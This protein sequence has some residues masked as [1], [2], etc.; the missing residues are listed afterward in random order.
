M[1]EPT[2]RERLLARRL[3][4]KG[5][6]APPDEDFLAEYPLLFDLLVRPLIVGGKVMEMPR[7]SL[8]VGDGDW[9]LTVSDGV[10]CQSLTVRETSLAD[11]LALMELT[12]GAEDAKWVAWRNREP[13]L[14]KTPPDKSQNSLD[15][16][17]G[18]G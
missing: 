9:I 15:N 13:R 1:S 18:G 6:T 17:S 12:V 7:L 10:L 5:P 11:C 8:T 14:P 2:K 4:V 16:G 3:A